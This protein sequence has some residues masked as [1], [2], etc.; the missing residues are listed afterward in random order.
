VNEFYR[1]RRRDPSH[2]DTVWVN[3]RKLQ[4]LLQEGQSFLCHDITRLVMTFADPSAGHKDTVGSCLKSLQ[5][6]MRRYRPCAHDPNGSDRCRVLHST[7]P[8]QVSCGVCSP[9]A[10]ESNDRRLKIVS[11]NWTPRNYL[12]SHEL[13]SNI[14]IPIP[15]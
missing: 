8:S 12:Q 2:P 6:I 13:N 5:D 7:D 11:H 10:Q 9:G 1:F 3:A 4:Q 14:Q 15:K